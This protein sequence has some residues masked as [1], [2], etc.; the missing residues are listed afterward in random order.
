MLQPAVSSSRSPARRSSERPEAGILVEDLGAIR[1]V[2][3]DRPSKK[4]AL[5]AS[6]YEALTAALAAAAASNAPDVVL[7]ASSGGSFCGGTDFDE[8]ADN[9]S[10]ADREA[11][12]GAARAFAQA[13]ASFPKPIVAAVG[14]L[15]LGMG[16]AIVLHCDLV[17]A[18]RTAAF[19]FSFAPPEP[20]AGSS[21]LL[22]ACVGLQRAS[23]WLL[24]G[25]RI[26]AETAL[27]AGL[28]NV[29][30]DREELMGAALA[31]AEALANLPQDMVRDTKRRLRLAAP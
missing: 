1:K 23:E 14:G 28:V 22:A 25:D 5:T 8:L 7:I 2:I 13:L 16:A 24:F 12:T 3:L 6:M 18:A 10:P 20:E 9:P 19:Q 11:V 4:N 21:V 30:V 17:V 29:M 26:D 31:R 15:A 27:R